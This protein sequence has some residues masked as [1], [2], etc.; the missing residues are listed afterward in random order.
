M[1][2]EII[3]YDVTEAAVEALKAKLLQELP[4]GGKITIDDIPRLKKAKKEPAKLRIAIEKKRVEYNETAQK[5]IKSV[6][7]EAKRVQALV[8]PVEDT[9]STAITYLEQEI[10]RQV[11]ELQAKEAARITAIRNQIEKLKG[12]ERNLLQKTSAEIEEILN[13]YN[14]P[15][16]FDY[17]EFAEEAQVTKT[18]TSM[19]LNYVLVRVRDIEENEKKI[20]DEKVKLAEEKAAF[21]AEKAKSWDLNNVAP[22]T[23]ISMSPPIEDNPAQ[24]SLLSEPTYATLSNNVN[25]AKQALSDSAPWNNPSSI[26]NP[27]NT[28]LL[29]VLQEIRKEG[30]L[31]GNLKIFDLTNKGIDLLF[32]INNTNEVN[33][34]FAA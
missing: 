12:D 31:I 24:M 30:Q 20:A 13:K 17:A 25:S 22:A 27:I 10:Q 19:A 4:E 23:I 7:A 8:N 32:K 16:N 34:E 18:I 3:N 21:E 11:A 33:S 15:D 9:Y 26:V 14:E 29:D 2:V 1:T 6:N 5:H 28:Q